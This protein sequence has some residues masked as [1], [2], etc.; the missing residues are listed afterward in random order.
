MRITI[1]IVPVGKKDT[2]AITNGLERTA[3]RP[4]DSAEKVRRLEIIIKDRVHSES[5]KK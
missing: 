1:K 4:V 3:R 2:A 5:S